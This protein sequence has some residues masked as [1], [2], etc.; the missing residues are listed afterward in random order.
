MGTRFGKS[1][2][3]ILGKSDKDR[4]FFFAAIGLAFSLLVLI[5]FVAN[6]RAKESIASQVATPTLMSGTGSITILV[7]ERVIP[8]GTSLGEMS[9]VESYWTRG[10]VP[11]DAVM[12]P[13]E[14]KE[15]FALVTL[16]AGQP[17]SRANITKEKPVNTVSITPGNRAVTIEVDETSGLEGHAQPGTRVD[18]ALTYF[19]DNLLTTKVIVQNARVV[20]LN[21]DVKG[22][23]ERASVAARAVRSSSR[24]ITLDV[25]P[26]DALKVINARQM[27]KLN[28]LM[29]EAGDITGPQVTEIDRNNIEGV[30][31]NT[32]SGRSQCVGGNKGK[33]KIQGKE[34]IIN[35]DGS[36]VEIMNA[37]P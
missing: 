24:T 5:T 20:S 35:C 31:P 1:S 26:E 12:D 3:T 7:P 22:L 14:V 17:I 30:A 6:F 33:M 4:L 11:P 34:Y 16:Q 8:A 10:E 27:G 9:Y 19:K 25:S 21:G 15:Y 37:E 13:A 2:P 36:I 28:L 18:V 23:N 29:R 32:N